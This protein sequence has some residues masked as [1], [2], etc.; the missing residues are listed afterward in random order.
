MIGQ[1]NIRQQLSTLIEN[2]TFPRFTIL[3]GAK[4]SGKKTL[5]KWIANNLG[6]TVY[7]VEDVKV[8][9]IRKLISDSYKVQTP[10][11]YIISDA[12]NMSIAAKNALLK[13]TE[14]P[15]NNARFIM[16]LENTENT[17]ET[18]RSRA[19]IFN[20]DVYTPAEILEYSDNRFEKLD[21]VAEI[22]E[23]PGEVDTFFSMGADFFL[24][25]EKVVDNISEVSLANAFK[26]ADMIAF[27]GEEDKYDLKLFLKAFQKI[28]A[29]R[30]KE[31][32]EYLVAVRVTSDILNDLRI[33]GINKNALFDMWILNI[34][35]I[36]E[37]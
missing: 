33:T 20:M 22:C 1:N 15:P 37:Q 23:T 32:T 35:D 5:C 3:V 24:F 13:V 28:C 17:L 29:S 2:K 18:V 12:D 14:E 7:K 10:I 34:R 21:I 6:E 27:K 8:D 30:Y 25:V 36:W 4:G 19:T 9:T 31:G 11:V 16:T 26:I